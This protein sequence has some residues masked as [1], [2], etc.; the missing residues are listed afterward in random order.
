MSILKVNT[1]QDK[2]GNTL[3][4]SDGSGNV[5]LDSNFSG[6]LPDN[7][8]AFRARNSGDQSISANTWTKLSYNTENLDTDGCYDTSNSRFTPTVAGYYFIFVTTTLN[9]TTDFDDANLA[10]YFNG[11]RD[12]IATFR[13]MYYNSKMLSGIFN[14][15]GSTD[16]IEAYL[17]VPQNFNTYNT[18]KPTFGG[19]RIIGA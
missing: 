15:N 10:F 17:S 14:F 8:P 2:G 6:V 19:Y 3:L 16:Y 9:G 4:S 13:Q 1:I 18:N 12:Q 7:T 11:S 5:T